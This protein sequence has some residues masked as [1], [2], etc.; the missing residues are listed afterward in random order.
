MADIEA[1]K[2]CFIELVKKYDFYDDFF[3][4]KIDLND[5]DNIHVLKD[6]QLEQL[7]RYE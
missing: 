7:Y 2:N 4:K 6:N 5:T 3:P 1:T